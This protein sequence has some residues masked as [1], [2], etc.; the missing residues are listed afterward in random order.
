MAVTAKKPLRES[1]L[2]QSDL[3]SHGSTALYVDPGIGM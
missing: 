1:T 2:G 3:Q